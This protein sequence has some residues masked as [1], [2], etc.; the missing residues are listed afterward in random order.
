MRTTEFFVTKI[1]QSL[2]PI[3]GAL[4][5]MLNITDILERYFKFNGH[6]QWSAD[7]IKKF[8][9]LQFKIFYKL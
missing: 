7:I 1:T 9:D 3:Y 5:S 8:C 4:D 6:L 2:S